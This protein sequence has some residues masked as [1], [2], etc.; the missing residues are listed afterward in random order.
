MNDITLTGRVNNLKV[1]HTA[2]G[3]AITRFSLAVD[4]RYFDRNRNAW[5]DRP[6]VW[7]DIVIFK[8]RLA[9]NVADTLGAMPNAGRGVLIAVTGS[10]SDNSYTREA[11]WEGGEDIVIR[12]IQLTATAAAINLD[13]V[14]ATIT[15]DSTAQERRALAQTTTPTTTEPAT[16][17]ADA[18]AD[19]KAPTTARTLTAVKTTSRKTT[20]AKA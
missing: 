7:H 12:R 11:N 16:A 6:T 19:S 13:Y 3:A 4:D 10:F 1:S 9:A 18:P 14:T 20:P 5:V 15:P 8:P 17:T 2:A